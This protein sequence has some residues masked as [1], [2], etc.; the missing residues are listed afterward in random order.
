M[1]F[2]QTW[3]E[4]TTLAS[5]IGQWQYII[6]ASQGL[7]FWF[8]SKVPRS[9]LTNMK[10]H[11]EVRAVIRDA[12]SWTTIGK[13]Q[14]PFPPFF[15]G[16]AMKLLGKTYKSYGSFEWN[17]SPYSLPKSSNYTIWGGVWEVWFGG[18]NTDPHVRHYGMTRVYA[19]VWSYRWVVGRCPRL[20][21][22]ICFLG[23]SL[24]IIV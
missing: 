16:G 2:F 7:L 19:K 11:S 5:P 23:K 6:K 1:V 13:D 8:A 18:P 3:G 12:V 22:T 17:K 20:A 24:F 15:R 10:H 14:L 21:T 4:S 9:L